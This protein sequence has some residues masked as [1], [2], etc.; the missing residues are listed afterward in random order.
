MEVTPVGAAPKKAA[1]AKPVARANTAT[2]VL[3]IGE[4]RGRDYQWNQSLNFS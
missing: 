3:S 1:R 4:I 2:A